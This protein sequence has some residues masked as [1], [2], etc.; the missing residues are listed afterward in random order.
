[1]L[2]PYAIAISAAKVL[3]GSDIPNWQRGVI[4]ILLL[5]SGVG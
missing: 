2:A 1:M 4:S 3:Q 5:Q